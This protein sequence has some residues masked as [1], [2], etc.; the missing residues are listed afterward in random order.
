[1]SDRGKDL[2]HNIVRV[3]VRLFFV[4][5]CRIR[6]WGREW[7][8]ASGGALLLSNH[9][10]YLDPVVV[11]LASD[12]RLCYLARAS[13]FGFAPLRWML[14]SL[15]GIPIDRDRGSLSGLKS[16]LRCLKRGDVVLLFPEGTRSRDGEV[17]RLKSGF[18]ALARRGRVPLLPAAVDGSY[19][20]WPRTRLL[21]QPA[22]IY[23]RFGEP[24][25]QEQIAKLSDAE[26]VAEVEQRIR[27]CH[28]AARASRRQ[29]IGG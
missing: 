23:V 28:A 29:A 25:T 18:C 2:W 9:Q 17:A 12:R 4:G 20:A 11:G 8:P 21:P 13:L 24:I 22:A 14:R 5:T 6:C 15:D 27:D 7:V 10:S 16:T 26:L 3:F 1:V 19:D